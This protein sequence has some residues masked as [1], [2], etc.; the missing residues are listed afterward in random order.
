MHFNNLRYVKIHKLRIL[1]TYDFIN[2]TKG[3]NRGI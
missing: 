1:T 2:Y 3:K